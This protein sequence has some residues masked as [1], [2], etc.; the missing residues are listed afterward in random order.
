M[1]IFR[2]II[3]IFLLFLLGGF[4]LFQ[5]ADE[6]PAVL[7]DDRMV[8]QEQ[9]AEDLARVFL[10]D[11]S[12]EMHY[13]R[14]KPRLNTTFAYP[15]QPQLT[16]SGRKAVRRMKVGEFQANP[17]FDWK[18]MGV[19][20]PWDENPFDSQTYDF[21][22]HALRWI[23]PLV[24][25][26]VSEA[27]MESLALM[28][29]VVESWIRTN[30]TPPGASR[31]AWDDHATSYRMRI[32]CWFWEL[33]RTTDAYDPDFARLLLAS[34]YQHGVYLADDANYHATSNHALHMD[35]S[36]LAAVVTF[37]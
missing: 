16:D 18:P 11:R 17:L 7:M 4:F 28:Q 25:A 29:S 20:P 10:D 32:F 9:L 22:L 19:P 26:W 37:S 24:D 33:W 31:Y 13:W 27:D 21:Y 34:I 3:I 6:Q 30:S 1:S 2:M 5:T 35:G 12:A 14:S 36:L 15:R 8:R 23:E